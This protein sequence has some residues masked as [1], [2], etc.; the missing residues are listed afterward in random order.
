MKLNFLNINLLLLLQFFHKAAADATFTLNSSV[1][2]A[3]AYI[4]PI[5]KNAS[6]S[7]DVNPLMNNSFSLL[8]YGPGDVQFIA[9]KDGQIIVEKGWDRVILLGYYFPGGTTSG[10]FT[11]ENAG[12]YTVWSHNYGNDTS[13][14]QLNVTYT[15]GTS[16][17]HKSSA[18]SKSGSI[19]TM[20]V[21]LVAVFLSAFSLYM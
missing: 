19:N 7:L 14:Y 12:E 9:T 1:T 3:T 17:K 18:A 8:I 5:N 20:L 13:D 2:N 11:L 10:C 15:N 4:K 16:S 21:L 6:V